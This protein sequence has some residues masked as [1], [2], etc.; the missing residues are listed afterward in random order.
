MPS[1]PV[2][3]RTELPR[4]RWPDEQATPGVGVLDVRPQRRHGIP[5][6]VPAKPSSR[7]RKA[8]SGIGR[9]HV[10]VDGRRCPPGSAP[11]G[12]ACPGR[13]SPSPSHAEPAPH[14]ETS[15][16]APLHRHQRRRPV[17]HAAA[18]GEFD[19][20][21]VC[22]TP[23]MRRTVTGAISAPGFGINEP[24]A[25]MPMAMRSSFSQRARG[26]ARPSCRTQGKVDA[27]VS[28]C[29]VPRSASS[30]R[31]WWMKTNTLD[32][33]L[34]RSQGQAYRPLLCDA[35]GDSPSLPARRSCGVMKASLR[36]SR[37]P[38]SGFT[39]IIPALR[40]L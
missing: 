1:R 23:V 22:G 12:R 36:R 4:S 13:R 18:A 28:L 8:L 10:R 7:P 16:P 11:A 17:A 29:L 26:A 38:P 35:M 9:V 6:P 33:A 3:R 24:Y 32:K 19:P 27:H 14:P 37:A 25:R 5:R 40:I 2:P 15:G 34:P 31:S 39:A 30:V 21:R 20:E